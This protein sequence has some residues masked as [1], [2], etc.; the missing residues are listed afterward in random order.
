M[1]SLKE[2]NKTSFVFFIMTLYAIIGYSLGYL[3]W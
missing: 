2:K 3:I 1:K